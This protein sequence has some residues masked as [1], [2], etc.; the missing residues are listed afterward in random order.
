MRS[1]VLVLL[2]ALS[3]GVLSTFVKQAYGEGFGTG[4]VVGA[5]TLLGMLLTGAVAAALRAR[6]RGGARPLPSPRQWAAL[7][8]TGA[9]IGLT[10]LLYYGAL[11]HLT[12]SLG[13][14]LLFQFTWMGVLVE[15]VHQRRRPGA[16]QGVS[17]AVLAVGTVLASGVAQEGLGVLHPLGVGLGL[18]S[19]VAYTLFITFSGRVALSVDPWVRSAGMTAGAALVVALLFPPGYLLSGAL[20]AGLG[21]WGLLLGFFGIVVPTV[22][23][24]MGLPQVGTGLGAIL[25]AA[26][27]PM[28][29]LCAALVLGE[30]VGPLRWVGVGL[31]LLG[32]ALPEAWGFWSR[33]A[34]PLPAAE[35]VLPG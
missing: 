9:P 20:G 22:C 5:Q 35:P 3:Y 10:G 7:L 27:L 6:T 32:V 30:S 24:T 31:V 26:E 23:F 34:R 28:A 14:V 33:R 29:T 18:L 12:A 13:V 11:Q 1:L 25:G 8:L 4:E 2:G 16:A 19:A 21:K 17:L 15:A